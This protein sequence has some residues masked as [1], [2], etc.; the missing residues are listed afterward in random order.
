MA[1]LD[2][3]LKPGGKLGWAGVDATPDGLFGVSVLPPAEMGGKPVVVGCGSVAGAALDAVSLPSLAEAVAVNGCSWVAAL[4]RNAYKILVIEEPAVRQDEMEQSVRWAISNMIDYPIA[5]ANVAW[6]KIPTAKLLPNRPP[7]IYVIATRA[8]TV[9]LHAQ[10]FKLVKLP[11]RAIDI[12]ETAHRNIA[13]LIAKPGEGLALLAASKR[14]VQLTITFNGE[15]YLDRHIDES[16]FSE[17]VDEATR[18]RA[19]ERVVLQIQRSL[20]FINRTLPFMDIQRLV[21]APMPQES[22]LRNQ[23]AENLSVTVEQLDLSKVLD[24]SRAP[25]LQQLAS[26]A[27]YFVPL[28]AALRFG[29]VKA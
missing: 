15:L 11:L 24:I 27:D 5:D 28:G 22:E 2:K 19:R 25:Q 23:V 8:E 14:G 21:L 9:A 17:S 13:T 1:A 16:L 12:R 29:D 4:N 26:Q 18:D 6:M 10:T 7:H 3:I 20:D